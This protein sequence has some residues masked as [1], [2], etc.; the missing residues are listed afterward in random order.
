[1]VIIDTN[2]LI[3]LT[4]TNDAKLAVLLNTIPGEIPGIVRAEILTGARTAAQRK[5]LLD[6]LDTFPSVLFPEP[7]WD[8]VGDNNSLILSKGLSVPFNDIAIATLAIHYD[9]EL[10]TR[11]K[12]FQLIQQHLPQLKLFQ[13]P[14]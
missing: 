9:A 12:Q 13:E 1:M 10:W 2:I 5:S 3:T 11:D 14:P 6:V 8:E 7:V 4:K